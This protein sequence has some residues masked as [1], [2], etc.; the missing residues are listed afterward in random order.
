MKRI[1]YVMLAAAALAAPACSSSS[2]TGPVDNGV[3]CGNGVC[4]NGETETSCPLDCA[5][6]GS[7]DQ[8]DTLLSQRQVD[9]NAALRIAALR[10]TGHV[11]SMADIDSVAKSTDP[12]ST[13]NALIKTYMGTEDFKRQMFYFWR[14][15]LK[16]GGA[17]DAFDPALD[18]GPALAA[19]LAV[20][21][22]SYMNLFT[23]SSGNC[24]TYADD[25]TTVTFTAAECGNNGPKAGVLTNPGIMANYFS[26]FAFRRTRW[27]QETFVCTKFPAEVSSTPTDVGGA[28]PYTGKFPFTSIS[29]PTNGNGRVNFLDVSAVV[30]ANCHSNINHIAP[31]FANYDMA[32][33]YQTAISVPTPL[34][35]APMAQLTDYL[36]AGEGLAWRYGVPVTDIPSLGAAMAGDPDV[37]ECGV[38]RIWNWALGKTDIVD[39]LQVVPPETIMDQVS[40]F[41]SNGY[42]LNDLI[43]AVYT[44]DDFVKF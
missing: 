16:Q 30:C 9:Y 41:T 21:N 27:V 25:G 23:Q 15:S 2:T 6:S 3:D 40:A 18:T 13:Y 20:T 31:L 11:P 29:S 43:Y 44:S 7:S 4:D 14:D 26:N 19:Q 32:G 38:A 22:G 36:P 34:E 28:A 42:K 10:L 37:A 17:T 5:G 8:W 1:S 24:P 33:Q 35:G 12:K 39:T